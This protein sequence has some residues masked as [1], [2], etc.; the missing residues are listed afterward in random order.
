MFCNI[1]RADANTE[2]IPNRYKLLT[3]GASPLPDPL[4]EGESTDSGGGEIPPSHQKPPPQASL[5]Y[6]VS[7]TQPTDRMQP[8]QTSGYRNSQG[9]RFAHL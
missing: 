7:G 8:R 4:H 5:E 2:K 3:A 6:G 1:D 9:H